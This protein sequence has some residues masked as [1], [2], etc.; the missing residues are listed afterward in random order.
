MK[1]QSNLVFINLKMKLKIKARLFIVTWQTLWQ[2]IVLL[3][4]L[5]N[6]ETEFV[7][8]PV[9]LVDDDDT[10]QT[11]ESRDEDWHSG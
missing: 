8:E 7:S 4:Q 1:L 5:R 2:C 6:G 11:T 10:S 9:E 3:L